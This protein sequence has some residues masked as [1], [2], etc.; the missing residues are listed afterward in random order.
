MPAM[1]DFLLC[2]HLAHLT[3]DPTTT[4]LSNFCMYVSGS[5]GS[6]N[7]QAESHSTV[8]CSAASGTVLE[9]NSFR[10]ECVKT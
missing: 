4:N 5:F 6:V 9:V 8:Y 3:R 1:S 10:R 7:I 2:N